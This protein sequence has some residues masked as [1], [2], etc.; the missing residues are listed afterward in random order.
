MDF[1]YRKMRRKR[2][3]FIVALIIVFC[4]CG[5]GKNGSVPE[6]NE[7]HMESADYYVKWAIPEGMVS[8]SDETIQEINQL[9]KKDGYKFGV[10]FVPVEY[11]DYLK[12]L[13]D[14]DADIAFVGTDL[15][16]E[17]TVF[18]TIQQ[19][20]YSC[21][22]TYLKDSKLF[23]EIPEVLW[24]GVS[25]GEGIWCVPNEIA[26]DN[27]VHVLF[28]TEKITLDEVKQFQ[29]DLFQL[30]DYLM[31]DNKLLY[32]IDGF[33]FAPAF[34]YSF[35]NGLLI[36]EDGKYSNP[37]ENEQCIQWI[38]LVNQWHLEGK[39]TT[40]AKDDWS[41]CITSDPLL[42]IDQTIYDFSSKAYT[43]TRFSAA[44]GIL[45]KSDRKSEAFQLLEL[46]HTDVKYGNLLVYGV[47]YGEKDGMVV[48]ES[49]EG[50]YCFINKMIFGLDCGLLKEED[51]LRYFASSEEKKAYYE[52][53]V[54]VSPSMGRVFPK[55]CKNLID[56][57]Q[58]Y[59][60]IV[61]SNDLETELKNYE[62]ALQKPMTEV[63]RK[64]MLAE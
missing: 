53:N 13:G 28:D 42:Y 12:R 47:G 44:T 57:E 40:D 54:V 35:E 18:E 6:R 33:K 49:G 3:R 46:F 30:R 62:K 19:G 1:V 50:M 14:I 39:V 16:G 15:P 45:S 27:G 48:N 23:S 37:L 26:Q 4:L 43:T 34:H 59:A 20:R 9:L 64:L 51:G 56:I 17:N 24:E 61:F 22:N 7:V 63:L 11:E 5:C 58:K 29:G 10:T 21:L 55:E 60:S 32:A 31:G 36:S 25:Y 38:K 41:I 8:V 2:C 52:K